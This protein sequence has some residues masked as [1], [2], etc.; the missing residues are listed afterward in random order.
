VPQRFRYSTEAKDGSFD[1]PSNLCGCA[2]VACA[3]EHRPHA[4]YLQ[5]PTGP[6]IAARARATT[7]A[8]RS[9][10]TLVVRG[11]D[12]EF[13]AADMEDISLTQLASGRV[14]G[15]MVARPGETSH[16]FLAEVGGKWNAYI[17]S[18]GR[19]GDLSP[20]LLVG[21]SHLQSQKVAQRVSAPFSTG[22]R[23]RRPLPRTRR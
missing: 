19:I 2:A 7:F 8:A 23:R 6:E 12:D 3:R 21:C 22:G 17:E 11:Q 9:L 4:Y 1:E 5:P 13:T 20:F 16:L 10:G 15:R 18:S 14:V